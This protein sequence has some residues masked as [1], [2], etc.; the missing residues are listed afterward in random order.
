MP[1]ILQTPLARVAAAVVVLAIVAVIVQH[2]LQ[3][4]E[5]SAWQV[6]ADAQQQGLSVEALEDARARSR[7]SPAGPWIDYQLA[8]MLFDRGEAGDFDRARQ[9]AE[10]S[11]GQIPPGHATVPWLEQLVEAISSYSAAPASG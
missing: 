7:G 1:S 4:A 2:Q 10:E 9:V 3:G 6:L 5:Q 11:L 8:M